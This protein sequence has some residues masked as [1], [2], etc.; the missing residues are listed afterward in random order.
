MRREFADIADHWAGLAEQS[1]WLDKRLISSIAQQQQITPPPRGVRRRK[2]IALLGGAAAVWPFAARAQQPTMPVIGFLRRTTE[3]GFAQL[4]AALPRAEGGRILSRG[5]MLPSTFAGEMVSLIG[6]QGCRTTCLPPGSPDR[7]QR[8][9]FSA[10]GQGR[11]AGDPVR[12][13]VVANLNRPGGN[14][15]GV[16]FTSSD[17]TAKQLGLTARSLRQ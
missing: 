12:V 15:T 17:L 16:V 14:V 8:S 13:G 3:A 2:F 7:R 9:P 6:F 11:I 10:R 4:V 5:K 1:D